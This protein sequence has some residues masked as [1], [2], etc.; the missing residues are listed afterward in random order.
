MGTYRQKI[1]LQKISVKDIADC[2]LVIAWPALGGS[3][4]VV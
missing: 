4:N 3:T 1:L 2:A